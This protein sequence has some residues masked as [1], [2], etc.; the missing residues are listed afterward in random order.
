MKL[1]FATAA[2]AI[3]I[4]AAPVSAHIVTVTYTGTNDTTT[5][6]LK[7]TTSNT[8]NGLGG[9]D[10][11]GISGNVS[12]DT[13]T[14]LAPINPPGFLTDNT[15]YNANPVFTIAGVGFTS[16]TLTYN[17]WGT[18]PGSYTLYGYNG[19]GYAPTS[20]GTLSIS[21]AVPEPAAWTLMI[22]GFA[23]TGFAVRRRAIALAA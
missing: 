13:V 6:S 1:L 17:L 22:A 16:S 12:G 8:K 2:A 14:G 19:S 4:A 7:L 23:M 20:I 15:Y 5:A 10:I 18:G 11:T 21:G 9:Y 3:A